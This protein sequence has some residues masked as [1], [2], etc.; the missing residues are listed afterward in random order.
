MPSITETPVTLRLSD[1]ARTKLAEQAALRGQDIAVVASE[2]I[3]Q[4]VARPAVEE[5][6]APFRQQVADSGL[7]DEQLDSFFRGEIDVHRH[8]TKAKSA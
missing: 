5:V 3:E 2:L 8:E 6:L 1:R 4:A 7:S